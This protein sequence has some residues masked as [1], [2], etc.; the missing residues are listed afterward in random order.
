M[1]RLII[2]IVLTIFNYDDVYSMS[3]CDEHKTECE[4]K[5]NVEYARTMTFNN[6]KVFFVNDSFIIY[7]IEN[8]IRRKLSNKGLF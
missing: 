5:F 6:S 8:D 1:I 2:I 3:E 7:D 4:Y